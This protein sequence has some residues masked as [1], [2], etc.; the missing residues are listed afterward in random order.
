MVPPGLLFG[1]GLLSADGWGQTFPKWPRLEEHMLM[2]IP[3]SFA[4]HVLP[5]QQ[6]TVTPVFPGGPPRTAVRSNP[7]SHGVSA[8]PRD[9]AHTKACVHLSRMASLF[10]PVPWSS[11]AQVPLVF[12]ARCLAGSFSQCQIPGIRT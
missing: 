5:P 10:P 11:C 12:N 6:A 3:K 1:W 8:F 4:S 2:H 9:P 7:D